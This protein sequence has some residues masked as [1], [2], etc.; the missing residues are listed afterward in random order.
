MASEN[1]IVLEDD[2]RYLAI[3]DPGGLA[4]HGSAC[5]IEIGR[6]FAAPDDQ[7]AILLTVSRDGARSLIDAL[8]RFIN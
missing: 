8:S 1:E 3:T 6:G 7:E 5:V 2:Y 4:K